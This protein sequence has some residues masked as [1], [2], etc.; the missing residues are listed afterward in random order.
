MARRGGAAWGLWR[1]SEA[2]PAAR[3]PSRER[4]IVLNIDAAGTV[5]SRHRHCVNH[6]CRRQSTPRS[7]ASHQRFSHLPLFRGDL[8]GRVNIISTLHR[9]RIN[10]DI[11]RKRRLSSH[12]T[13][14]SPRYSCLRKV[15]N[16]N[17]NPDTRVAGLSNRHQSQTPD[18]PDRGPQT[19]LPAHAFLV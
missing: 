13:P 3:P 11:S 17:R 14:F 18:D 9:A 4:I 8:I 2:S 12:T 19:S 6:S 5:R 7:R 10:G 15:P 16:P 1:A